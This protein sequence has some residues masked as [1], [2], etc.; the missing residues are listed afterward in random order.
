MNDKLTMKTQYLCPWCGN[1][2]L[3]I[4]QDISVEIARTAYQDHLKLNC[5]PTLEYSIKRLMT[6]SYSSLQGF[7]K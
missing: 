4:G 7:S 1:P 3:I 6:A 5:Q 2:Y